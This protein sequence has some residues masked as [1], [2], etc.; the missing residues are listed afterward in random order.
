MLGEDV[1]D[2]L[3]AVED[4]EVGGGGDVAQL[5]RRQLAIED[6]DVGAEVHGADD[7]LLELAPA[8]AGAAV[9][10]RAALQSAVDHDEAS[11]VG[12]ALELGQAAGGATGIVQGDAHQDGALGALDMLEGRAAGELGLEIGDEGVPVV[13]PGVDRRH[14]L[15]AP[16][17]ILFRRGRR[18]E[19][20]VLDG[21]REA[22]LE[23]L[24]GDDSV[25]LEQREVGE[26]VFGEAVGTQGGVDQAHAAK[27]G[28]T[29]APGPQIGQ[30]H[31]MGIADDDLVHLAATV[32]DQPDATPGLARQLGEGASQRRRQERR[33]GDATAV[34]VAQGPG[35]LGLEAGGVA[36][37]GVQRAF[38]GRVGV[39]IPGRTR[40]PHGACAA[41]RP[42]PPSRRS[43][44]APRW[45]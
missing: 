13:A 12:Q 41:T 10:A 7:Q 43:G 32:E 42:G 27:A 29:G 11:G 30:E 19:V 22:V 5:A 40:H 37:Q 15:D 9:E 36:V 39:R 45:G 24:D 8:D 16:G 44:T 38:L 14:V 31:P 2:Q 25:E 18:E 6:E 20:G 4:L 1:E 21:A 33:A 26:I 35:L 17:P 3:R 34:Q 28:R 23:D